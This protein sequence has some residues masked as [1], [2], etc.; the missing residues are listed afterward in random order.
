MKILR[1]IL[2]ILSINPLFG[3]AQKE[4]AVIGFSY[5]YG[6]G[7]GKS[8][9]LIGSDTNSILKVYDSDL[10]YNRTVQLNLYVVNPK[11]INYIA[12][13]IYNHCN[14]TNKTTSMTRDWGYFEL[15]ANGKSQLVCYLVN[16]GEMQAYFLGLSEYIKQSPYKRDCQ[17]L[18]ESFKVIA[19]WKV[20]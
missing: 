12:D 19:N 9:D 14:E 17:G 8:V 6:A 16:K 20:D 1:I 2:F 5:I 15:I 18:L 4:T 3:C 11:A 10:G 7:N 13:Y